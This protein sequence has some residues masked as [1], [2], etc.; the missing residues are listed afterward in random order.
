MHDVDASRGVG[1]GANVG[2]YP[3]GVDHFVPVVVSVEVEDVL[4]D[5]RELDY[6]HS[7]VVLADVQ[8]LDHVDDELQHGL[9][10]VSGA[11]WRVVVF[12]GAGAVQDEDNVRPGG[13]A[14]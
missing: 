9:P 11:V 14:R 2:D 7:G 5:V 13:G 8:L 3:D 1:V 4:A 6:S 12:D 10:V